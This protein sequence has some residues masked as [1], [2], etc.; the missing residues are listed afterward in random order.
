MDL[1]VDNHK[2][3]EYKCL[4]YCLSGF[5]CFLYNDTGNK[6]KNTRQF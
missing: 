5:V 4:Q 2:I 1:N 6:L 3:Y